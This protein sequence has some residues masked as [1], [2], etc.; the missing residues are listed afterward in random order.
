[1]IEKRE[2]LVEILNAKGLSDRTIQAYLYYYDALQKILQGTGRNLDQEVLNTF[3]N[4]FNNAS[5]CRAFLKIYVTENKRDDLAVPVITGRKAKKKREFI[6]PEEVGMIGKRMRDDGKDKF[7]YMLYL[8]YECALRRNETTQIRVED[9]DWHT[10]IKDPERRGKLKISFMG[11]KGK[12]ERYVSVP[13]WLMKRL[14]VYIKDTAASMDDEDPIFM[15][16]NVRWHQIFK[17]YARQVVGRSCSLHDLRF[18]KATT[19]YR[20]GKDVRQ[21][22]IRLGHTRIETTYRYIDPAEEEELVAWQGEK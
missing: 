15:M 9:F 8:T 19:W 16:G 17:K 20:E 11:A 22:K 1:M 18:S 6:T 12:K 5:P 4:A 2:T 10:W 21:I 3:L 14:Y 7:F 13:S